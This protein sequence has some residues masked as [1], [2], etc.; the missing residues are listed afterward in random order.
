[1]SKYTLTHLGDD[2]LLRGLDDAVT[3]DRTTTANL[4]A[5]M[6]E[7]DA[8]RLYAPAGYSSMHAYCVSRLGLSDDSTWKRLQ[9]ARRVHGY[10][11]LLSALEHGRV[12]LSGLVLLVPHLTA[13]NVDEL[14]AAATHRR[15]SQIEGLVARRFPQVEALRLDEGISALA[16]PAPGQVEMPAPHVEEPAHPAPGQVIQS[17][18]APGQVEPRPRVTP[19]SA[20]RFAVQVTIDAA[21]HNKLRRAQELLGGGD[22]GQVL[23]RALDALI[24][25]LE[26]KKFAR[27]TKPRRPRPA[28]GKRTIPADVRRSVSSR[29]G[30]RCTYLGDDGNRCESRT[31]LEFDHI[32]PVARGGGANTV[33]L[34]CRTHNQLEA[35]RVFGRR[36][37]ENKRVATSHR[38]VPRSRQLPR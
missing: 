14:L 35:E 8:R 22:V 26:K 25:Q 18:P 38:I 21:T 11:Q 9:V 27:V 1:M 13:E 36:F 19:I 24:V 20:Q 17:V 6:A 12:H 15:K 28:S 34:L 23:D 4:L 37:M 7:V 3:Q 30:D 16:S 29:D 32:V 33:R 10:P 2:V 31:F 5:H